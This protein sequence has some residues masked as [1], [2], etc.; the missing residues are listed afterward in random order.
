MKLIK[1]ISAIAFAITMTLT[2]ANCEA[3]KNANNKQKGGVIGAAG[4]AII[5]A[6]IGNNVG[7]GNN[8]EI[9]AVIGGVIGG[10]AG[11]LIGKRMDEQA[12]KIETEIPGAEVERVDNGI[13]VTFDENSGVYFDTNKAYINSKSKVTLD[14]LANIFME[15]PDTK[16][17]VVGHT[18]STGA[19]DYNM[20]LS[21]R[22]AKSVTSYLISDGIA[23]SR[24]ETLW[25]GETQPKYDNT[26]AEGR[27]KNR[28]VN[29]AIVPN[30]EMKK[31]AQKQANNIKG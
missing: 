16:I 26:T 10:T 5:G 17:L 30:E 23:S 20:D 8:S 22:R 2:F 15:F 4:G 24:F 9:G 21:E 13:V 1:K 28:R 25:Y 3:T 29:V 19:A 27:A 11:V 6:I 14:K 12:K 7:D 18:D 31:E